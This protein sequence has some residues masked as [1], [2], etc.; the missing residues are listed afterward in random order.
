MSLW[1]RS[2]PT[3]SSEPT[4]DVDATLAEEWR[5]FAESTSIRTLP[6]TLRSQTCCWKFIWIFALVVG[7]VVAA[8]QLYVVI[9]TYLQYETSFHV[10]VRES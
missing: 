6:K 3:A 2:R 1:R 7:A 8:Y 10:E 4:S 5:R 9:A